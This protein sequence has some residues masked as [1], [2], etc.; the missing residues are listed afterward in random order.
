M[1][2]RCPR[3]G[4][5][6]LHRTN[7]TRAQRARIDAGFSAQRCT[8]DADGRA[9]QGV[10]LSIRHGAVVQDTTRTRRPPKSCAIRQVATRTGSWILCTP[11]RDAIVSRSCVVSCRVLDAAAQASGASRQ[12]AKVQRLRGWRGSKRPSRCNQDPVSGTSWPARPS[13]PASQMHLRKH[14]PTQWRPTPLSW[15]GPRTPSPRRAIC[16]APHRRKGGWMV[17]LAASGG[18]GG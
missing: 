15:P 18:V 14:Q 13:A 2:P 5:T 10:V 16:R 12:P 7:P 4:C 3:N 8:Q 1:S 17:H 6:T 11:R 9:C